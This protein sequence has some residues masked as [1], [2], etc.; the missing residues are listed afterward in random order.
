MKDFFKRLGTQIILISM[1]SLA[2]TVII[3]LT[4]SLVMFGTYND[5]ILI[6]RSHVGMEVLENEIQER[7]GSLKSTA[8][9]WTG[10]SSFISAMT[11]NDSSYFEKNWNELAE[12]DGY[13][14]SIAAPSGFSYYQSSNYP[15]TTLDLSAAATGN[16]SVHGIMVQDD[17]LAAVYIGQVTANGVSCGI[18]VG[19]RL[20]SYDWLDSLTKMIDCDITIFKGNTHYSTT[21][22]DPATGQRIVGTAMPGDIEKTVISSGQAYTGKTTI[23]GKPYYVSYEPMYDYQNKIVGA[24]FAGNNASAAYDEFSTITLICIIAALGAIAVTSFIL[25]IFTRKK[26]IIPIAQVTILADEMQNG[27]LSTTD[28]NYVFADNEVGKFAEKL[29]IA[30]QEL[31]GCIA[32]IS[33]IMG[34]MAQGDFTAQPNVIYPGDFEE[35]RNNILRIETDLGETLSS[36]NMSSDEVLSGSS[37]MAEGSQSLADGT[38]RQA[39]AIQQISATI[40]DVSAKVAATAKNAERAGE[41]SKETEAEVNLQDTSITNMVSAMNEIST[42]SKEI[43]KII[44]TIEDISFQTNILALNAAV[45]AARAGDAGK[46]FAVVA[47]EVR[48]LANK[49]AEAAKSTNALINAAIN[50]VENGS[51]I[52]DETAESMKKV[53]EKTAASAEIIGL[54]ADASAEQND[55]IGQITMGI[56][57]I[58]QVVQMNSATAEETAAS[59]EELSGQSRI[60][61]EQVSRFKVN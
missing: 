54:I 60:L 44:K 16:L 41:I 1:A 42:T 32:D 31:S 55:A 33:N 3:V 40:A 6:E 11:F 28:V 53:K 29:R 4:V 9:N 13:F 2:V 19:F 34:Y 50:A 56:D 47:D 25:F 43:E 48:N 39:A 8:D 12:G 23:V 58:S 57:Q 30:K 10:Q 14:C 18:A 52:A 26:V 22:S 27:K 36:M 51:K 61:K 46:G 20:D 37:Q 17:V 24:Y 59:S 5:S 45:E 15:F 49:S 7:I 38:T 21:I 35:I